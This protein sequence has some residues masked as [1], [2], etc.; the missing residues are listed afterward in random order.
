MPEKPILAF[1]EKKITEDVETD[2]VLSLVTRSH[3]LA[4][5]HLPDN[6]AKVLNQV[7]YGTNQRKTMQMIALRSEEVILYNSSQPTST[8]VEF[9]IWDHR[10]QNPGTICTWTVKL[11][12][13]LFGTIIDIQSTKDEKICLIMNLNGY[14]VPV[15]CIYDRKTKIE[16]ILDMKITNEKFLFADYFIAE[17]LRYLPEINI[18][19]MEI[20]N[21]YVGGF[22]V[23][24]DIENKKINSFFE[25]CDSERYI[26]SSNGLYALG[27]VI[28]YNA[29]EKFEKDTL[30][31][32]RINALMPQYISILFA[33]EKTSVNESSYSRD[34]V[35]LV[36]EM[37]DP[38]SH[39]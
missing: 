20:V 4:G 34:V 31:F 12:S 37:L 26:S 3:K 8:P 25:T 38:K 5:Q 29:P 17:V 7:V 21:V 39:R 14:G 19:I 6:G 2:F 16:T 10:E 36:L 23:A 15:M 9:F 35:Q 27:H 32:L 24:Y 28:D 22:I 1:Q 33:M 13:Q 30:L 11:Q 18:I